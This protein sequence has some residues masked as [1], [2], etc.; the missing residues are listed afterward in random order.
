[1]NRLAEGFSDDTEGFR[2]PALRLDPCDSTTA[3]GVTVRVLFWRTG[4]S[5][6]TDEIDV[7]LLFR[8]AVDVGVGGEYATDGNAIEEGGWGISRGGDVAGAGAARTGEEVDRSTIAVGMLE[9]STSSRG[10]EGTEG[11][12]VDTEVDPDSDEEE[13][14]TALVVVGWAGVGSELLS[15]GF[16]REKPNHEDREAAG[17]ADGAV[18]C[19]SNSVDGNGTAP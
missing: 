15:L 1:M 17:L 18:R 14:G 11:K 2:P 16:A 10:A 13:I 19:V 6:S 9:V 7:V 5:S 3:C 4:T 12:G 8:Y